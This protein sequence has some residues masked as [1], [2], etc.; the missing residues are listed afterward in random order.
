MKAIIQTKAG[1]PGVLEL[2]EVPKPTPKENEVLIQVHTSTV[3]RGDVI[4]RKLHPLLLLPLRLFGVRRKRTPGHEFAGEIEAVGA[5]V[6]KFK[7]GDQ[8]FGT[9]TGLSVGANAAYL[10]L[11][12][13][14]SQGV[15]ERMPT[16]ASFEQAA[17]LPVGGMTALD[18]LSRAHLQPGDA[19]LVYGASGSVGTYAVQLARQ[20]FEAEVTGVCSTKNIELVQSLGASKVIDYTREDVTQ[21]VQTFDLIFDA[22][23]KLSPSKAKNILKDNGKFLSVKSPTR[24]T[25]E[26]LLTLKALFEAGKLQA[27][28]DSIYPL[29]QT[30]AAHQRVE[31]G[32]KVG[33]VV[34]AVLP[35][36]E[37]SS[38]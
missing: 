37:E 15:L 25:P 36:K 4:L 13:A 9:T 19:V 22:V 16:N 8:V 34:I 7:V 38:I 23:G 31:T 27:V 3:T 2:Q 33:N 18:L 20:H 21:G 32:H 17:A 10:C 6:T 12:Q 5:R 35:E 29:E 11:P 30:A 1:P 26:H 14:W 24:E 28:I